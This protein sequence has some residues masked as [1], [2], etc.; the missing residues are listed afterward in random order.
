MGTTET[1]KNFIHKEIKNRLNP[2]N[3][4]CH[5]VQNILSFFYLSEEPD[6]E[7]KHTEL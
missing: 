5:S 6:I 4:F 7:I 1:I 3:I 2:E